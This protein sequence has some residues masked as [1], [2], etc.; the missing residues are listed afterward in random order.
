MSAPQFLVDTARANPGAVTFI[1]VGPLTN[2]A[3]ALALEPEL[4]RLVRRLV[5][6]GGAF[7]VPGNTTPTAE[8]NI[9]ADPQAAAQVAAAGFDATW[10]GLDVTMQTLLNRAQWENRLQQ[11]TA[12][13]AALVRM[14]GARM[15]SLPDRVGIALHDPACVA[16][17]IDPSLVEAPEERVIVD[18]THGPCEGTTVL[19]RPNRRDEPIGAGSLTAR[20]PTQWTQTALPRSLRTC[21]DCRNSRSWVTGSRDGE[22]CYPC[23]ESRHAGLIHTLLGA[24]R[25]DEIRHRGEVVAG[26]TGGDERVVV[27][28]ALNRGERLVHRIVEGARRAY[29]TN[30]RVHECAVHF[31]AFDHAPDQGAV[32]VVRVLGDVPHHRQGDR[33]LPQVR[34]GGLAEFFARLAQIE[35]VIHD[36]VRHAKFGAKLRAARRSPSSDAS[37]RMPPNCAA[38]ANSAAVLP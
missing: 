35:D 32:V 13:N 2:L 7:R 30:E 34:T 28:R 9:Y 11:A 14:M 24:A 8:F 12:P 1:F 18:A 29:A 20:R 27:F 37:P 21:S 6:M 16:V 4:P 33:A 25:D 26:I 10:V 31:L 15:F 19:L 17:A 22:T 36:L 5:I 23:R 38:V 3:V